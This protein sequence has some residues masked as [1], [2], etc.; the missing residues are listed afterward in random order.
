MEHPTI[1][2]VRNAIEAC[3]TL[4]WMK[5]FFDYIEKNKLT[6]D[7]RIAD[8][9]PMFYLSVG[10]VSTGIDDEHGGGEVTYAT[11]LTGIPLI[12]AIGASDTK[13][14]FTLACVSDDNRVV[15]EH[16]AAQYQIVEFDGE[17]AP[18]D[19]REVDP[20]KLDL[21]RNCIGAILTAPAL[22]KIAGPSSEPAPT[23][24]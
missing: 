16:P 20:D 9:N 15:K 6:G 1:H 14:I 7:W 21:I 12:D 13:T 18:C 19:F 5:K 23:N 10:I 8:E 22:T 3:R 11:F 2:E 4:S 24:S 17:E